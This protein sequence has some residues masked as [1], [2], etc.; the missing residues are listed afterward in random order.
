[1]G[2]MSFSAWHLLDCKLDLLCADNDSADCRDCCFDGY[3]QH[4]TLGYW[5]GRV[6]NK[7][8]DDELNEALTL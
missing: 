4:R 7:R 8:K 5:A 3:N 6:N 1:M 2:R